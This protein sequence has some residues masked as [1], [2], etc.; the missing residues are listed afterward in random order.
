MYDDKLESALESLVER[1][2]ESEECINYRKRFD[3]VR[4]DEGAMDAVGRIRELN[5]SVQ[6]MSEEEYERRSEEISG[7]MEELCSDSRVS[8]FILAEVDFSRMFQ[9]IT[10]RVVAVLDE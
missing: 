10:D 4:N 9:Y 5:M 2:R 1:V 6:K 7:R 3:E 8:D